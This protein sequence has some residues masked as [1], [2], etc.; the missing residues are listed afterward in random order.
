MQ[1]FT[2]SCYRNLPT[3]PYQYCLVDY[4]QAQQQQ[5]QY[6]F[7][8]YY[9]MGNYYQQQ[10]NY[11]GMGYQNHY[12]QY[13]PTYDYPGDSAE[14]FQLKRSLNLVQTRKKDKDRYQWW[15]NR[16]GDCQILKWTDF[17]NCIS[18][19]SPHDSQYQPE[20]IIH[21]QSYSQTNTL[22]A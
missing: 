17:Y 14:L 16:P 20:K 19:C 12:P 5:Q 13:L 8:N 11:M 2:D 9:N 6:Q 7:D 15:Y 10:Y 4:S 21:P 18:N 22:R 1:K 3:S